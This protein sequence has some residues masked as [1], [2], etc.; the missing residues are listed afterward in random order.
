M[1]WAN[2]E[3]ERIQFNINRVASVFD[4]AKVLQYCVGGPN[5]TKIVNSN[6]PGYKV[7]KPWKKLEK[8]EKGHTLTSAATLLLI[9][10]PAFYLGYPDLSPELFDNYKLAF[11]KI[12]EKKLKKQTSNYLGSINKLTKDVVDEVSSLSFSELE[13]R[14]S[15]IMEMEKT[16]SREQL[17][18][19]T[20]WAVAT[21]KKITRITSLARLKY[22]SADEVCDDFPPPRV[23]FHKHKNENQ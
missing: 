23:R 22:S 20:F 9:C 14:V 18:W 11:K 8:H 21:D 7:S 16:P 10:D 2:P 17:R 15:E 12:G 1:K 19:R 3:F 6:L 4:F 13:D 5:V